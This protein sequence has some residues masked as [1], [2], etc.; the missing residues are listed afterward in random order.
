MA[1]QRRPRVLVIDD[2]PTVREVISYLLA[3]FGCD[4]QTAPDG[5]NGLAHFNEG[6]WDL[7]LTDLSMPEMNGW[8]VAEAI[9][10][11]SSTIPI[12]L[13]TGLLDPETGRRAAE[14]GL[15]IVPKPF[16]LESLKA[17]LIQALPARL[18]Q[19]PRSFR[20]D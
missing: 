4:C 18:F 20:H 10:H 17:V 5:S 7:V 11:R 3:S 13:L 6:G 2:D 16:R 8:E 15:P 12:V 19:R 14:R 9:R 1:D